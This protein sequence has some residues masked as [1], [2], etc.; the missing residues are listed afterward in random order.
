MPLAA[1]A[2]APA[3]AE[4]VRELVERV[5]AAYADDVDR[6]ARFPSESIEALRG[7]GV[8]GMAVPAALGGGGAGL[9]EVSAVVREV[10]AACASTA[11]VLAMHQI[12]VA[13][14]VRHGASDRLRGVLRR[15]AA[16]GL[17]LA[18]ATTE[19]GVGGDVRTSLC[20]VEVD[21]TG[22]SLTKQAPVISYG[23]QAGAVLVTARRSPD[24]P[25]SDQVLVCCEKPA[26]SLEVTG[27]WDTL[28]FRGT[29]S[30]GYVL[31]WGGDADAQL[32]DSYGTISGQT[33]LPF[34]H[35]VWASVWLGIAEGAARK[36]HSS[37]RAAA[38]RQPGTVPPAAHRLVELATLLQQLRA[39]TAEAAARYDAA[40]ADPGALASP[41]AAAAFNEL[42]LV[43]STTV[44]DAVTLAMR[45]CGIASYRLD[46]P[47]SLGRALRDAHG[48]ALMVSN[49]RIV[50]NT[51]QLLL[52]AKE[53]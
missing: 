31:R 35:V 33:M 2:P 40:A 41:A 38:R 26:L 52:A 28:G 20:A 29:C 19:A 45:I 3:P 17:L 50:S 42:K 49:D 30:N 13:C 5:V 18:S 21:G 11:M 6:N 46:S 12:Q 53:L 4:G 24:S 51:A 37:V 43:A 36:A 8:L 9:A 47:F 14:L 1:H 39:L 15:V 32:T 25:P 34:S 27:G 48:A 44:V 23:E 10:G 22:I 16:E 7:A